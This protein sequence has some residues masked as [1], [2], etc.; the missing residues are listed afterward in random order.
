MN[1][2]QIWH[3]K[4]LFML[5]YDSILHFSGP[6]ISMSIINYTQITAFCQT[7]PSAQ[8]IYSDLW[9]ALSL[10]SEW[11]PLI[12]LLVSDEHCSLDGW[13]VSLSELTLVR[14]CYQWS[15]GIHNPWLHP[16]AHI[17]SQNCL[18][19]SL[20]PVTWNIQ[21]TPANKC[22]I[23]DYYIKCTQIW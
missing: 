15:E 8:S 17:L 6:I 23:Q 4:C 11:W 18:E 14:S 16:L 20:L 2:Q 13:M 19:Y 10:N 12:A 1:F 5:R 3:T 22:L 21:W 7:L 9:I